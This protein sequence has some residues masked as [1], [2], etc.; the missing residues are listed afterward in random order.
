MDTLTLP[1]LNANAPVSPT[2]ALGLL[3]AHGR[4]ALILEGQSDYSLLDLA[5]LRR[6]EVSGI[7][8]LG[9]IAGR[10]V[11]LLENAHAVS[12][13]VDLIR[14]TATPNKYDEFFQQ[15]LS[16]FAISGLTLDTAFV[17]SRHERDAAALLVTGGYQ[18]NGSP[19]HYFPMPRVVV[20]QVC[21][22]WPECDANGQKPTIEAM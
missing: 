8:T 4:G 21:P 15:T 14:P 1:L 18:C 3:R 17:V 11:L 22:N 5:S 9:E 20:G 2:A 19:R 16:D 12:F 13:G 7:A 10:S 6:A